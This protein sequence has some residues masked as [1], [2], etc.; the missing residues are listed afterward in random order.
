M[1]LDN[2]F[3]YLDL[4]GGFSHAYEQALQ[5]LQMTEQWGTLLLSLFLEAQ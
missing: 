4:K 2:H 5:F 1:R 3:Y